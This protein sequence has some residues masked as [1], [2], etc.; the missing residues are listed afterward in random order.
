MCRF[1][2]LCK[3]ACPEQLQQAKPTALH[4]AGLTRHPRKQQQPSSSCGRQSG[5]RRWQC[6]SLL[7]ALS[8]SRA[9]M[10]HTTGAT[11][12]LLVSRSAGC[13]TLAKAG[14]GVQ[15]CCWALLLGAL[16]LHQEGRSRRQ[17]WTGQSSR[18][19]QL[20]SGSLTKSKQEM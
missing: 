9:S 16:G 10:A 2:T 8:L 4:A 12:M 18:L 6:R 15:Q 14:G 1:V 20:V 17:Q 3:H 13:H 7:M 19:Q 5:P 11:L